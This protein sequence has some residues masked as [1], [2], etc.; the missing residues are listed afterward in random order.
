MLNLII[1]PWFF[2]SVLAIVFLVDFVVDRVLLN[3]EQRVIRRN[4]SYLN[5]FQVF[6]L[7]FIFFSLRYLKHIYSQNL[8][9]AVLVVVILISSFLLLKILLNELRAYD[10]TAFPY[11][12]LQIKR[13]TT[14]LFP[15]VFLNSIPLY[16][17]RLITTG[18]VPLSKFDYMTPMVMAFVLFASWLVVDGK[19]SSESKNSE[20]KPIFKQ[21]RN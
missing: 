6:G 16:I 5:P 20:Y 10:R 9:I 1:S 2:F 8:A 21:D 4:N 17:N 19:G 18:Y 11:S 7:Y 3:K 13:I 15:I 14:V 12:Y